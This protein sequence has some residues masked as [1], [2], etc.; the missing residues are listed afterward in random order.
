MQKYRARLRKPALNSA[1]SSIGTGASTLTCQ[2][3]MRADGHHVFVEATLAQPTDEALRLALAGGRCVNASQPP[4]ASQP[5]MIEHRGREAHLLQT[6]APIRPNPTPPLTSKGHGGG[7]RQHRD[8]GP[9]H[10]PPAFST[11]L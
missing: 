4:S 2:R 8:A 10:G 7:R 3:I 9:N 1:T 11:T 6:G 5:L